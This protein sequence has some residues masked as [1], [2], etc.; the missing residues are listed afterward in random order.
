MSGEASERKPGP[1][2]PR[3]E[4]AP[5]RV[6]MVVANRIDGD[7]RVQK[8][9]QSMAEEGWEVHLVGLSDTGKP[10][11]YRHG[12]VEYHKIP[13]PKM[14]APKSLRNRLSRLRYPLAYP[15]SLR[16]NHRQ[17]RIKIERIELEASRD[18]AGRG[19]D[20][21]LRVPRP[22]RRLG[23][24][25]Q[26]FWIGRRI[27]QTRARARY[28]EADD[29]FL[30]RAVR[31]WWVLLL[32]DRVWRRLDY[33]AIRI[34]AALRPEILRLE[35]D[36]VHAHDMYPIGLCARA[37]LALQRKG[38]R[39]K[40]LYDAHEFVPGC[41]S[42]PADRLESLTRY[43]RRYLP[44]ADAVVTVSGPLAE[45]LKETHGLARLPAVV[46]NAP[47]A[48]DASRPDPGNV[49]ASCGLGPETPLAVYSGWAAPER[50]IELIIEA[51]RLVPELHVALLTNRPN[52][53]YLKSL[54]AL[55]EEYG[56]GDRLHFLD[57]VDYAD[58]PR[59]LS[60]A[61]M[62]IHPMQSGPVN[63][64]IALPNKFFE[65]SHAK[66]PLVVSDVKTLSAEVRRLGNGEVFTSGDLGSLVAAIEK[67]LVDPDAYR[68]AYQDEAL[69]AEYTWERQVHRYVGLYEE[70]IGP[71]A[72][73]LPRA[74][75]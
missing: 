39:V 45:L 3:P 51:A 41:D 61:D 12:D 42:L 63:H 48:A 69:M 26:R 7:S 44:Y 5:G 43:E 72:D 19:D 30:E 25:V 68:V 46:L 1:L 58:L 38:K 50:K 14:N 60:T 34:E 73:P 47:L 2:G 65:Y 59:Y 49:R 75:A 18:E 52:N 9:A 28:L 29:R 21:L 66:L 8:S 22:A 56:I 57:Y 36:L 31:R 6:V 27:D 10:S 32:G 16:A 20:G 15:S 40:L 71:A 64:E 62:G 37:V 4:G 54:V 24:K 13:V 35:P 53:P 55:G 67:I 17:T 74:T 33:D 70:L 23:R 11:H